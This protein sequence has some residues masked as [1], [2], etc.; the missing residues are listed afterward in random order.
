[1]FSVLE[2]TVSEQIRSILNTCGVTWLKKF[3]TDFEFTKH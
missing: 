1:M 2:K 3:Q